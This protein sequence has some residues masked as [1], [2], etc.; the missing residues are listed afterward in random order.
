VPELEGVRLSGVILGRD[1]VAV[2]RTADQRYFLHRGDLLAGGW[3]LLEIGSHDVV[4]GKTGSRVILP[5]S[6]ESG[7]APSAAAR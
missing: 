6:R 1:P 3:R 2:L 7:S 4:L 5:L